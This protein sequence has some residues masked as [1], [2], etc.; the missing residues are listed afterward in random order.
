MDSKN[1]TQKYTL[2]CL[3][4]YFS[5]LV[6]YGEASQPASPT[7][8]LLSIKSKKRELELSKEELDLYAKYLTSDKS[9]INLKGMPRAQVLRIK[10]KLNQKWL[11]NIM[12]KRK[13]AQISDE[14]IE[15]HL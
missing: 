11:T 7:R 13:V 2:K 9:N 3:F 5:T 14:L 15:N 6:K 12:L 10:A 4:Y 1:R 8:Q